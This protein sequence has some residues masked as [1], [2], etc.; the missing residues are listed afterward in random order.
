MRLLGSAES[1]SGSYRATVNGCMRGGVLCSPHPCREYIIK[2]WKQ[3]SSS[4]T[5][6]AAVEGVQGAAGRFVLL[7][8]T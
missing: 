5:Q 2:A 1:Q 4:N 3:T 6:K 7:K 8:A